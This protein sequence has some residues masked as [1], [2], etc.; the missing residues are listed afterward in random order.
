LIDVTGRCD[1]DCKYCY[2][3]KQSPDVD[4]KLIINEARVNQGPYI[5][6]GGEPTLR[7]DLPELLREVRKIGQVHFLTNGSGFVDRKYLRECAESAS[8]T[9]GFNCIGFSYHKDQKILLGDSEAM[10]LS[11]EFKKRFGSKGF[12]FAKNGCSFITDEIYRESFDSTCKEKNFS[13]FTELKKQCRADIYVF[14]RFVP[15]DLKEQEIYLD[16]LNQVGVACNKLVVVGTPL[17]IRGNFSAYSS[18]LFKKSFDSPKFFEESDFMVDYINWNK[19]F[20]KQV[21]SFESIFYLD[22]EA[23]LAK[24]F[25]TTLKNDTG[26]YLYTDSTHVSRYGA[27][28]IVGNLP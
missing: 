5:L 17:Q 11:D 4:T 3:D 19:E 27:E 22:T 12:V 15:K 6:T 13:L 10:S 8:F 7:D 20:R 9:N 26:D 24:E 23:L 28:I 2:H 1:L 25:P 21:K 14:N 16:F 18:L